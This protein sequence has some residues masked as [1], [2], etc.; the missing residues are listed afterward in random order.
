[1]LFI[2]YSHDDLEFVNGLAARLLKERVAI[3]WDRIEIKVGE[4]L[5]DR[6]Q[7]AIKE[8]DFLAVV[9]S[10]ASTNSAWC[11][12]ELNAAL[13]RQL[14]EKRVIVLPLLI[15]ECEI[16]PFLQDKKY[17]NFVE[18]FEVG[19]SELQQAIAAAT[20]PTLGTIEDEEFKSDY[21]MDWSIRDSKLVVEVDAVS[22]SKSN[23]YS[24][25]AQVRITGNDVATR[26]YRQY[27]DAGLADAGMT[28]VIASCQAVFD[29]P[30][31]SMVLDDSKA[32]DLNLVLADQK[33]DIRFDISFWARR[34]GR[35]TGT[36]LLYHFGAIFGGILHEILARKR[37]MT[38]EQK[39][40]LA[41]ILVSPRK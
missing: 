21:A 9:L 27:A 32:G 34:V 37:P 2:S 31:A 20:D 10:K 6:I 41:A 30:D 7:A 13:M 28:V 15:E 8:S 5:L 3:W 22:F 11:R 33:S 18:D 35:A 1:M 24:V 23:P 29:V 36:N 12:E 38:A 19:F 4:S 14:K 25:M 17:A 16:P 40:R 26:R 39:Q